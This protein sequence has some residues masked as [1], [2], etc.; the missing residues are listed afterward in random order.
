MINYV[1][2]KRPWPCLKR[3]MTSKLRPYAHN[4]INTVLKRPPSALYGTP[5][6]FSRSLL[7]RALDRQ[8][9]GPLGECIWMS[10]RIPGWVRGPEAVELAHVCYA[11][12]HNA[13]VVEV[14]AFLGC[15]TV[16]MAG[17]RKLKNSGEVHCVDSFD[18]S[19]DAFSAP[20]YSEIAASRPNSLRTRFD[21]NIRAANLSGWVKVH[22]CH[23][24]EI[25][26]VWSTP[27]DLLVLDADHSQ[28][29]AEA[30]YERW[31]SHL[32]IGGI[33]AVHNSAPGDYAPEHGGSR[34]LV[35]K[36]IHSPGYA[37]VHLVSTFTFARKA[38]R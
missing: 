36:F 12:P 24:W 10:R 37:E 13:V 6:R 9:W 18:A 29:G 16:L 26:G 14:G 4:I 8:R 31:S 2:Q 34:R 21:E 35:E 11:L 1:R 3:M 30:I 19:G 27:I 28:Q 33:I 25:A 17:A 22:Q 15:A 23:D 5:V 32:K 7:R 38:V 20:V